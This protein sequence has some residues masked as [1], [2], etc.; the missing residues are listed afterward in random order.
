MLW[1]SAPALNSLIDPLSWITGGNPVAKRQFCLRPEMKNAVSQ[2]AG[3]KI[4][5]ILLTRGTDT[6]NIPGISSIRNASYDI[7]EVF[8]SCGPRVRDYLRSV[9]FSRVR[10]APR[11]ADSPPEGNAQ[12]FTQFQKKSPRRSI[13]LI[14]SHLA[15]SGIQHLFHFVERT[16]N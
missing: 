1:R 4:L 12:E 6:L 3:I 8:P 7:L 5:E 14:I 9:R 2:R 13:S 10:P 11:A 15:E 16:I